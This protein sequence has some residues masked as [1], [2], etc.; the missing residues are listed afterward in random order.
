MLFFIFYFTKNWHWGDKTA[1]VRK[2]RGGFVFFFLG[3][4]KSQLRKS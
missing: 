2:L 3:G 1:T 4:P